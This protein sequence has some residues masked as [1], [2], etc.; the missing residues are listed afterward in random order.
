MPRL[1][2]RA[3]PLVVPA[4]ALAGCGGNENTLEPK[5]PPERAISHLWWWT[6]AGAAIG[7]TVVCGLLLL[8]WFRRN[9]SG[10]PFGGGDRAGTALVIGLGIVVPVIVL[11]LLFFWSDTVVLRSTAAPNPKSTRMTVRVIGRQWWWEVRYD[12]SKAVTANEIHIPVG[13]PVEVVGT[14]A[15]VIHSFWIPELNRKI[16]LIPGRSNRVLLQAD[17]PG[18]YKG[19]CS[20]FCGIQHAHMTAT[21]V[22]QPPEAFRAWLANMAKPARAPAGAQARRG[23]EAF[24]ADGCGACHQIRGTPAH[25]DVGPDLTHLRTRM[26]L[27][28][29]TIPNDTAHLAAWI[30]D[31]QHSKP[32]NRM[33]ALDLGGTD[34]AAI[35]AYLETLE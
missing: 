28:A 15:D 34:F 14:T 25:A 11:S 32:G 35:L 20:E 23:R 22:A 8:G 16:D 3:L 2:A 17:E 27:A 9:R 21:V 31:P 19:E 18:V 1:P 33:P 6:T 13:V 5:S 24:L 12:G 26:M 10:L 7:F 30:A 4:I 29:G